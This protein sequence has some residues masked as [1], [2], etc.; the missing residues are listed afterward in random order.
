MCKKGSMAGAHREK[1]R[2]KR[3]DEVRGGNGG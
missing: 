3:Q 1:G 2:E